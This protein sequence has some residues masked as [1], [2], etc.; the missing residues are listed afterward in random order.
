VSRSRILLHYLPNILNCSLKIYENA[1]RRKNILL[2]DELETEI[3]CSAPFTHSYYLHN[4]SYSTYTR[5]LYSSVFLKCSLT[6]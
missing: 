3:T 5:I 6:L 2:N 1:E 4:F